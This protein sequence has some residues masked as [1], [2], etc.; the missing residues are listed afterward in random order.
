[1]SIAKNKR[2][3]KNMREEMENK[4][5]RDIIK[6]RNNRHNNKVRE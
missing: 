6:S 4:K 3:R 2:E 5:E 1:V